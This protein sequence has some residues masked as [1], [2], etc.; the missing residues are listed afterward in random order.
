M[1]DPQNKKT[2]TTQEYKHKYILTPK[3]PKGDKWD[4]GQ[5]PT[6]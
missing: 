3:G 6:G 5:V 1:Q 2:G 4:F